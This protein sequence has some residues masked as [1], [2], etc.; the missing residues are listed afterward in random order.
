[1]AVELMREGAVMV[2]MH[3]PAGEGGQAFYI[4]G[5]GGGRVSDKT[6]K[7]LLEDDR[8]Q[9]AGDYFGWGR[10]QSYAMKSR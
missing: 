9:P 6:A 2:L 1:M 5:K 3:L 10:S 7:A 8:V 4:V